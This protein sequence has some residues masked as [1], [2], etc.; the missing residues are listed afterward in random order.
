MRTIRRW[1]QRN[2]EPLPH[3]PPLDPDAEVAPPAHRRREIAEVENLGDASVVT[4]TVTE[5]MGVQSAERLADLLDEIEGS[6]VRGVVLDIQNVQ[7]MDSAC[8]GTL[9]SAVHRFE[10]RGGLI[11]L[12]NPD[13]TVSYLFRITRLDRVFPICRDVPSALNTIERRTRAA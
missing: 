5:L 4:F 10:K 7:Q 2:T 13:R 9:V 1:F 3:E 8:L 6:G 12:V 11:A